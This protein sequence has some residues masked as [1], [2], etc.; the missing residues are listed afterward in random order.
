[1]KAMV[2]AAGKG[3]RLLPLT[4][5]MPKPMVPVVGKPTIQHIFELLAR[6]GVEET[7]V[8]V[9]YLAEAIFGCYGA[10]TQVDGMSVNIS[11]EE[12]L[13][14][15]A[16]GVKR[17]ADHFDETFVVIMGDA[18]TD[19]DLREVVAFH[20]DRGA[21]ATLALMPVLDTSQFGVV[22]LDGEGGILAF[23]EK[24]HPTEAV[25]TL[26]NTGIYVLELE[27]LDYIPEDTFFD[28]ANDLFPC[29]LEAG[30]RFVGYQGDFYWSDVGTL[31]AYRQAQADV[32]EGK[33]QAEIPGKRL[34]TNLWA[35]EDVW[36]HR[37]AGLEGAV[38]LGRDA[39]IG[40]DVT[41]SGSCAIGQGCW[42][43]KGATV[44]NSVVLHGASVGAGAYLEDC[45]VGPGYHVRPGEQ[46]RGEALVCGEHQK[47]SPSVSGELVASGTSLDIS[48]AVQ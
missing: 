9:Y 21:L 1:M 15:T 29:L 24:P 37:T 11:R 12:R 36:L 23:Q 10:K 2:L 28:F 4:G 31:E 8:N 14:G 39:I 41:F 26:A 34:G 19:V 32:L 13:M 45:I 25:S 42:V 7:H 22:E 30:E 35:D 38:M 18:L 44:K 33:V 27:A 5:E 16:G 40:Q 43:R 17:L 47:K 3:T 46:I 6:Y 48:A 20:K